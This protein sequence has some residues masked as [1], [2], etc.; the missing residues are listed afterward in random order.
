M[1]LWIVTVVF[2][3]GQLFSLRSSRDLT[4]I[5]RKILAEIESQYVLGFISDNPSRDDELRKLTVELSRPELRPRH[6]KGYYTFADVE[7]E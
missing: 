1:P 6:R 4:E 7:S 5:Y 3:G 2:S